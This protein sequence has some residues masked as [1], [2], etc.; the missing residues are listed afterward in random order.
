[1]G[2]NPT[3]VLRYGVFISMEHISTLLLEHM[4][5]L[6][7][8]FAWVIFWA[9]FVHE[10]FN[11]YVMLHQKIKS[12]VSRIFSQSGTKANDAPQGKEFL[13]AMFCLLATNIFF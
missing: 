12:F 10:T 9:V 6:T 11:F 5:P 1:M 8:V 7:N 3:R 4:V 13:R 2:E